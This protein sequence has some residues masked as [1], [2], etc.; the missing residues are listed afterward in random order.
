[1]HKAVTTAGLD[2]YDE[3]DD[4]EGAEALAAGEAYGEEVP[5]VGEEQGQ[6]QEDEEYDAIRG[7]LFKRKAG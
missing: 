1:M 3:E 4:G 5:L 6:A 7:S 2:E